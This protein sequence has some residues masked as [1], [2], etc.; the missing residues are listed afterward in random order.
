MNQILQAFR[1]SIYFLR[2]TLRNPASLF[3]S[4]LFPLIFILLFGFLGDGTNTRT[5]YLYKG[6][7]KESVIIKT[8]E[9]LPGITINDSKSDEELQ[10]S[11]EKGQVSAAVRIVNPSVPGGAYSI[12]VF[13]SAAE[14]IGGPAVTQIMKG[15][16]SGLDAVNNPVSRPVA[17]ITKN[18]VQGR[19][20]K[21][22]DFILPGQL[23]FSILTSALFGMT[24]LLVTARKTLVLKRMYA[25]PT[26][27]VTLLAGLAIS[28]FY[29]IT[30]QTILIVGVGYYFFGFTLIHGFSSFLDIMALCGIG[31]LSFLGLA[32]IAASIAA[33]EES[34]PPIVNIF[35]LPQ[36]ILS[37]SF[38]ASSLFPSWLKPIADALPLTHL[39]SA[40]RA[41]AFEG[42]SLVAVGTDILWLLGWSV[43]LFIISARVFK[44]E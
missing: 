1:L 5:I 27:R 31:L 4:F 7:D 25:S 35:S 22:I 6:Y 43:V 38:F 32:F 39:N 17:L 21:Q 30:L 33:S 18:L 2:S 19:E 29:Q 20:Y 15:L 40:M 34:A 12:N 41:V 44:W 23:G 36:L 26:S 42:S 10:K 9:K 14:P 28:K 3:F 24:L 11:L 37:G 8:L 16:V 13:E